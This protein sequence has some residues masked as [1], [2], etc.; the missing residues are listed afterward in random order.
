MEW[1]RT[2]D[3]LPERKAGVGYSQVPCL[4]NKMYKWNRYGKSGITHQVQILV[5]NHEYQCWDD[6]SGDDHDCDID[7]VTHWMPLP[8]PPK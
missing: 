2:E 4:V 1:I 7:D 6:E 8:E 3:R 5:F